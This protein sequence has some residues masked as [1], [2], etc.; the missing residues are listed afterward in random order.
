M[1]TRG[2]VLPHFLRSPSC[3]H[4][5]S[6]SSRALFADVH[7]FDGRSRRPNPVKWNSSRW[8]HRR[9]GVVEAL[10]HL[11]APLST[12]DRKGGCWPRPMVTPAGPTT[13]SRSSRRSWTGTACCWCKS[14]RR[15]GLKLA[16]GAGGSGTGSSRGWRT[17][18]DQGE[19]RRPVSPRSS[20]IASPPGQSR[21]PARS[22][23]SWPDRW[24]AVLPYTQQPAVAEPFRA[25]ASS[26]G[27]CRCSAGNAGKARGEDHLR[28]GAGDAGPGLSQRRR[29]PLHRRP[30]RRS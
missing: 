19:Q 2:R 17:F 6:A 13:A 25:G 5:S 10:D 8:R 3:D 20:N 30:P 28:R 11:G 26:T 15:A 23:G 4:W 7:S 18:P 24:L 21:S 16:R 12:E 29:H 14:T 27:S 1:A 22:S 9:S